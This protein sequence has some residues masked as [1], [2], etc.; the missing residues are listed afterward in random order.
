[1]CSRG[2]HAREDFTERDDANWM[3]VSISRCIRLCAYVFL[4]SFAHHVSTRSRIGMPTRPSAALTIALCTTS[5][6]TRRYDHSFVLS[7][8]RFADTPPSM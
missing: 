1:M 2:A 3:K 4:I 6:S 7:T 5:L 8:S